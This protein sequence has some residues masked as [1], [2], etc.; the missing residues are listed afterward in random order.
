MLLVGK[1]GHMYLCWSFKSVL[2]TK[3]E[4]T[5]LHRHLR[6]PSSGK[7]FKL[8]KVRCTK[9]CEDVGTIVQTSSVE[10]QNSIG[11]GERY[12]APL[13]RIFKNF[14]YENQ[15]MDRTVHYNLP[16]RHAMIL[17]VQKAWFLFKFSGTKGKS[18]SFDYR[19]KRSGIHHC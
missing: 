2:F 17:S 18:A 15:K 10:S 3:K 1:L 19:T 6:H 14:Q 9:R 11:N 4:L 12:D 5:K 16:S 7:L 13:R 8:I